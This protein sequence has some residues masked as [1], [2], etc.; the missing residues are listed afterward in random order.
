MTSRVRRLSLSDGLSLLGLPVALPIVLISTAASYGQGPVHL[1]VGD[2]SGRVTIVTADGTTLATATLDGGPIAGID[3]L[4]VDVDGRSDVLATHYDAADRPTTCLDSADLAVKWTTD[5]PTSFG[6]WGHEVH[7]FKVWAGDFDGDESLDLLIPH[8]YD[9]RT[10]INVFSGRDGRRI[11]GMDRTFDYGPHVYFD[12]RDATWR[13]IVEDN[14]SAFEH[15]LYN[16]DLTDLRFEQQWVNTEVNMWKIGFVAESLLDGAPRIFGGWYGR[17]VW[18]VD[19]DGV[20]QWSRAYGGSYES[21][22]V[23][24]GDLRGDGVEAVLVGGTHSTGMVQLDAARL[25]DGEPLWTF[26]DS[27]AHWAVHPFAVEDVDGDGIKEIYVYTHGNPAY[28]RQPKYQA[29]DGENGER[30]WEVVYPYETWLVQDGRLMDVAGDPTPEILLAV[31]D[32]IEARDALTGALVRT[33]SF[34]SDVTAFEP[35][36]D[37]ADCAEA[38]FDLS[39]DPD[40]LVGG[41]AARICAS[42]GTPFSST[43]LAY[44]LA[45]TGESR[46]EALDVTICIADPIVIGN[47]KVANA[48]GGAC[49]RIPVPENSRGRDVWLQAVQF[50]RASDPVATL[51]R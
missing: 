24:A 11:G 41:D 10:T 9:G 18:T 33:Y 34:D 44:S 26:T 27:T 15:D 39:V 13:L 46:V 43:W 36:D 4:D 37:A 31:D 8:H 16:Y 30:L 7:G 23:Y 48:E 1:A 50:G 42:G 32:T 3:V 38:D 6:T 21:D 25:D 19:G 5:A 20:T 51:V 14:P 17:R 12:S 35:I 49:W 40:P 45:G 47:P 22:T 29:I 2:R 28:D